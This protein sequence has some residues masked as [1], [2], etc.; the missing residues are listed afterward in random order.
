MVQDGMHT[1]ILREG[2]RFATLWGNNLHFENEDVCDALKVDKKNLG[3]RF[4]SFRQFCA[5]DPC[6]VG[7]LLHADP[8]QLA[9]F[10][11]P[12]LKFPRWIS[13]RW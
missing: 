5:T 3:E 2:V 7:K 12:L 10:L 13:E 8:S 4:L 11:E 9:E 6:D 1:I